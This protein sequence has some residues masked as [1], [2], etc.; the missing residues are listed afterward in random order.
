MSMKGTTTW[1]QTSII[2]PEYIVIS[3]AFMF[4]PS[5]TAAIKKH[6]S[7]TNAKFEIYILKDT[8]ESWSTSGFTSAQMSQVSCGMLVTTTMEIFRTQ[9]SITRRSRAWLSPC[10]ESFQLVQESISTRVMCLNSSPR[11]VSTEPTDC[12]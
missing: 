9:E 6:I 11:N 10:T 12:K 2:F 5:Y 3:Y 1:I 4:N 7:L 8:R